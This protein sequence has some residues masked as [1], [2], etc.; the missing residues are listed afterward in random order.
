MVPIHLDGL[1]LPEDRLVTNA[2]ADF[3]RLPYFEQVQNRDINPDIP[4][5]SEAIVSVPFQ[6]QT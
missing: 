1:Y 3:R 5:L 4:Y 6:N 2:T